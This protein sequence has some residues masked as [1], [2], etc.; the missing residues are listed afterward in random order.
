MNRFNKPLNASASKFQKKRSPVGFELTQTSEKQSRAFN[1]TVRVGKYKIISLGSD[2]ATD[3]AKLI[4][5]AYKKAIVGFLVLI[6]KIE[7]QHHHF[8][9]LCSILSDEK[10]QPVNISRRLAK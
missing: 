3:K 10:I 2:V 1:D 4:T 7:N 8:H 6:R 5:S 9:G